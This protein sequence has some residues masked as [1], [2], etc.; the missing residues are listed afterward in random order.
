MGTTRARRGP[1]SLPDT[2]RNGPDMAE[3]PPSSDHSEDE[4]PSVV[5]VPDEPLGTPPGEEPAPAGDPA[6]MPGIP[7]DVREPPDAG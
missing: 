6:A 3:T 1:L 5:E 7:D 4:I 2:A